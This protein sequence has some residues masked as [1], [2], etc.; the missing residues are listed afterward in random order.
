MKKDIVR[1]LIANFLFF[2]VG[3]DGVCL[4]RANDNHFLPSE[5][6][7]ITVE[8][9]V[10]FEKGQSELRSQ[11]YD[12]LNSLA[13]YLVMSDKSFIIECYTKEVDSA[14]FSQED[15]E[16]SISR[17]VAIINYLMQNFDIPQEKIRG[18]GF[19]DKSSNNENGNRLDFVISEF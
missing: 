10:F 1:F 4:G 16:L 5:E 15:L 7:V 14:G 11:A 13:E 3:S 8:N 12:L 9:S 17:V 6:Y 18:F 2:M 19:G